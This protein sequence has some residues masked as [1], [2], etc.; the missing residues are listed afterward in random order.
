MFLQDVELFRDLP[1][2]DLE[3]IASLAIERNYDKGEYVFMEGQTR[4]AIYFVERGLI[5]VFKV[6]EEGREQI[7]NIMGPPQM[8]PHV[9]FFDNTPYPGTAEVLTP[10]V[11]WSIHSKRFDE[12]MTANPQI[13]KRLMSV[14]GR[15][16]RQL[17]GKLQELALFDARQRVEALLRHF[18]EEHGHPEQ[19]GIRLKL[20]VTHTELAQMVGMSRESVNRIWN[21]LRREGLI[22]RNKEDWIIHPD[23]T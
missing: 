20:P 19:G 12:L 15:R 8:F 14:M 9:G 23:W 21:Q 7:V 17:Q 4:E 3:R 10:A 13:M 22:E 2:E 5:K 16:I 11:L 6:D 18:C 1:Q